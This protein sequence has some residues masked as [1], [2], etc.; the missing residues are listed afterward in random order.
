MAGM[1][2]HTNRQ[3]YLHTRSMEVDCATGVCIWRFRVVYVDG[4]NGDDLRNTGGGKATSI[5]V[6]VA[7]GGNNGDAFVDDRPD[8][9]IDVPAS[10]HP[11]GEK[12]NSRSLDLTHVDGAV[13]VPR[14]FVFVVFDGPGQSN[15]GVYHPNGFALSNL[16]RKQ[17]D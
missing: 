11:K 9:P 7:G 15:D 8:G 3:R 5:C 13:W 12:E 1:R 10:F 17:G 4:T 16:D 14:V 2:L 6:L